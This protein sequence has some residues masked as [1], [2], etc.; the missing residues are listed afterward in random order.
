MEKKSKKFNVILV[1]M[2]VLLLILTGIAVAWGLGYVQFGKVDTNVIDQAEVPNEEYENNN[3]LDL[4]NEKTEEINRYINCKDLMEQFYA[5]TLQFGISSITE[6]TDREIIFFTLFKLSK[7]DPDYT[8]EYDEEPYGKLL[9]GWHKKIYIP[10]EVVTEFIDKYFDRKIEYTQEVSKNY[11]PNIKAFEIE[12][13]YGGG[14]AKHSF[15]G[16]EQISDTNYIIHSDL[17]AYRDERTYELVRTTEL[18]IKRVVENGEE[19]YCYVRYTETD[20]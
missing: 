3:D 11:H 9:Q 15:V 20:L 7:G 14:G 1:I 12:I 6:F 2:I 17:L 13:G 4:E 19:K 10:E 18:E 8:V 5:Y 16:I